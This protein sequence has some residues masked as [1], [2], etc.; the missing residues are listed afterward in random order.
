MKIKLFILFGLLGWCATAKLLAQETQAS[1]SSQVQRHYSLF[2]TEKAYLSFDK[3]YYSAGDTLWF[4]SFLL[5]ADHNINTRS[6]RL[7]VEL[8][9]DSSQLVERL[10]L[11]LNNG[12]GFGQFALDPKLTDGSYSIRAYT[13]WQQ[14]LGADFYFSKSF[15]IGN[16]N[17]KTWL[18]TS[19]QQL[20]GQDG[21]RSLDIKARLSNTKNESAG[22][23]DLELYLMNG[24]KRLM[25]TEIQTSQDG[26][27]DVKLP[28]NNLNPGYS[29]LILDKKDKSKKAVLPLALKDPDNLDLQ[30]MP[31]GGYLV[32]DIYNKIAFKAIGTDGLGQEISGK[33]VNNKKEQLGTFAS[34]HLGMGSFFLLP[35]K[36]E[37]YFAVFSLN[38]KEKQV[39]LPLAKAEGTTLRIDHLAKPDSLYVFVKASPSKRT[40]QAYELLAQVGD[41]I[42][43]ATRLNLQNGFSNLRLPK[44]IFP[45]GIVHFTLFSPDRQP[46]NERN[47]FI[48]FKQYVKLDFE[49]RPS[50]KPKD[51]IAID[52]TAT[53]E[54]G[55]PVKGT[56]A[57]AVTDNAQVQQ[58]AKAGNINS[59]Y[60]LQSN[61]KGL[62]E[63][64]G[65]YFKT[66]DAHSQTALDQLMLTQGWIGYSWNDILKKQESPKF[67]AENGNKITGRLRNL[68]NK[69][70]PD[71][72]LTLLSLGKDVLITDTVSDSNGNF[73]FDNLPLLDSAAYT[74]K[75]KNAKG[76]VSSANI[77]VEEFVP[78]L[79]I[80]LAPKANPWYV[81]SD[82]TALKYLLNAKEKAKQTERIMAP[83][84]GT[85]LKEVEIKGANP[86]IT[87][88][89][90]WDARIKQ[91]ITE[92]E[93]K[94]MPRKTL[95][96]L[97][98]EKFKG[99]RASNSWYPSCYSGAGHYSFDE[100]VIGA[101]L[102]LSIRIDK[103]STYK[104]VQGA[105]PR[106]WFDANKQIFNYLNAA[107]IKN[108]QLY[109]GCVFYY[110]E[111][112]TRSGSGPWVATVPG[113]YVYR[114]LPLS[115]GKEFYSPKYTAD[116]TNTLPDLRS[117]IYWNAN[118][119]TDENG[120]ARVS[121]YAA[122][123]PS[124]YTI[125]AEGTD[126]LGRFG[127]KQG[128]INIAIPTE[129]K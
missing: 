75:I 2:P 61:L 115:L 17:D 105:G 45:D 58:P 52:I 48:N 63:D 112:T 56:F 122:D 118:V 127:F 87:Y 19:S 31:E 65:W 26:V 94:K 91:F 82:S 93:L 60:L 36:D 86:N 107:D 22:Y 50:Y 102:I 12:L 71:I 57:V 79:P 47:A 121:F 15:Y 110:L 55:K 51:S 54:N 34:T 5:N 9:N 6:D 76:K 44:H 40:D 98:T 99:F 64:A 35:K 59:Y 97:L 39:Q 90:A 72:K 80:G 32:N 120:K 11:P 108:I 68:F 25:R 20:V 101:N 13:N 81:N 66:F 24:Q 28:A 126:L 37:A 106:E 3:P 128:N 95:L 123:K 73:S 27:F 62:V 114:P 33:I 16:A 42:I 30:F 10:V 7:Y 78:A 85:T 29:L 1:V 18:L 23:R 69:P 116:Q 88:E 21:K 83:L 74:I 38:G 100:Y 103:I 113:V 41:S 53:D 4:K 119:I 125:K 109:K 111:I 96:N 117:T 89:V 43:L 14:N 49:T 92:E 46:L 124:S 84:T 8:F 77:T 70:V 104:V 129:S 67:I